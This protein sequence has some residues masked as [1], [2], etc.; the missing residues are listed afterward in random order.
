MSDLENPERPEP[1]ANAASAGQESTKAPS[2]SLTPED[3]VLLREVAPKLSPKGREII[4]L[5]LTVFGR[6]GP[7][8]LNSLLQMAGL[9]G[10]DNSLSSLA[11]MMPLISS[12]PGNQSGNQGLNPAMLAGLL[13]LLS[14]NRPGN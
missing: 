10:G 3:L 1:E 13:N 11:T 12:L 9:L 7:P 6:G 14:S 4:H 5:L 2:I 8:D